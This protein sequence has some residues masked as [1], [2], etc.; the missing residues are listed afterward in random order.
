MEYAKTCMKRGFAPHSYLK[1]PNTPI[2]FTSLDEGMEISHFTSLDEGME[3][4]QWFE[5]EGES[6]S[7]QGKNSS[8]AQRE[9]EKEKAVVETPI[10]YKR[11]DKEKELQLEAQ[12]WQPMGST[13]QVRE[14]RLTRSTMLYSGKMYHIHKETFHQQLHKLTC[15]SPFTMD[16]LLAIRNTVAEMV[17]CKP[18]ELTQKNYSLTENAF[19]TLCVQFRLF[20]GKTAFAGRFFQAFKI[21]MRHHDKLTFEGLIEGLTTLFDGFSSYGDSKEPPSEEKLEAYFKIHDWEDDGFLSHM[22]L[23][24]GLGAN[25][26]EDRHYPPMVIQVITRTFQ[27]LDTEGRGELSMHQWKKLSEV[28]EMVTIFKD[29]FEIVMHR[30]QCRVPMPTSIPGNPTEIWVQNT[31][32]VKNDGA[33]KEGERDRNWAPHDPDPTKEYLCPDGKPVVT[34]SVFERMGNNIGNMVA[35][36]VH[37]NSSARLVS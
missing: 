25:N 36:F 3:I 34:V 22:D 27:L 28:P 7:V 30:R 10:K 14:G 8:T 1:K 17:R 11:T 2:A 9:I 6:S 20:G 35:M 5:V 24:Q 19:K 15:R 37:D 23:F 33:P 29:Y 32:I 18:H 21:R 16:E 4:S 31:N 13:C 12:E 26:W